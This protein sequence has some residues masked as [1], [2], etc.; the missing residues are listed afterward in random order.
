MARLFLVTLVMLG[1]C[2]GEA[3]NG[4]GDPN[5]LLPGDCPVGSFDCP[6]TTGGAC[7]PGLLCSRGTCQL[8]PEAEGRWEIVDPGVGGPYLGIWGSSGAD[9]WFV[10]DEMLHWHGGG[11]GATAVPNVSPHALSGVSSNDVWA[12]G[13][14]STIA[15]WNG[16]FWLNETLPDEQVGQLYWNGYVEGVQAVA[17]DD[18]WLIY[19]CFDETAE[20]AYFLA[21]WNGSTLDLVRDDTL[22]GDWFAT[23][24]WEPTGVGSIW[25][26]GAHD[27]WAIRR[28][29]DVENG[30]HGRDLVHWNGSSWTV[31]S[32]VYTD[33]R[34]MS[35]WYAYVKSGWSL[36]AQE[37][38][39]V[40]DGGVV[41]KWNGA[42]WSPVQSWTTD[43][44]NAVWG[45][46]ATDIWAVG[47]SGTVIHWDGSHWIPVE[48]GV[49]A[50]LYSVWGSGPFDVWVGG[51]DVLLHY[52][53]S[54]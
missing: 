54:E 6:C 28:V 36:S 38:W 13:D 18:V 46:S 15:R 17:T 45:R 43:D 25:G 1:A 14:G 52:T 5:C 47:D 37:A 41:L 3:T 40:G 33:E 16:D 20:R 42:N 9:V 48:S 10:A 24:G 29:D 22:S 44:L 53:A 34:D 12:V 11:F 49:T 32:E 23:S 2:A 27:L 21:R 4:N 50:N 31:E 51:S 39:A 35:R 30:V 8:D 19:P 26:S 7:D